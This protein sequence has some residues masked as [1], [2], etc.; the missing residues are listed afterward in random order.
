[1]S[2]AQHALDRRQAGRRARALFALLTDVYGADRVVLKAGRLGALR[3][4][5]SRRL[6]EQVLALQKLIYEDPTLQ[7]PPAD[8]GQALSDL[9]EEVADLIARRSLEERLERRVAE[10]MQ[11]RQEDYLR[12]IKLQVLKDDAGPENPYTQRKLEWLRRLEAVRLSRSAMEA[13]R[14]SSLDQVVGQERAI[15]AVMAKLCCPY[16]QHILLYGPPGVGKTTVARLVLAEAQRLGCSP[17]PPQ[18]PFVEV[19]GATL[20]WDPREVT[21]PL[22]GSVH[23]PI[24]QG[25]RRDLADGGVPEPKTGLVTEAHGGVLFIDEI[26]EI[27]PLLQYKL[28][29]VLEDKRV[30]YDSSYYDPGDQG[31]PAYIRKLFEEGAPADFVLIGATTRDPEEINPALRSR[32]AEVFFD[33]LT[34]GDIQRIVAEAAGRLGSRLEPGVPEL[35]SEYTIEARKAIGLLA[36]A[37]GLALH[38][39]LA[40]G[41]IDRERRAASDAGGPGGAEPP[42]PPLVIGLAEVR[43][44][45]SHSRLPPNLPRVA[46]QGCEVGR[47]FGVGV[48][49]F[50]GSVLE[51]EA[52]ALPAREKGKGQIRF[53]EAAGTM[54]RD[55]VFNAASVI[56]QL[57]GSDLSDYDLHI[58]LVGGG[59][60]DGPSAGAAVFLALYSAVTGSPL[61]QDLAVTGEVSIR[62]R[63]K[64]VGGIYEKIYGAKQAGMR[65]LVL[66]A[67]ASRELAGVRG[68]ELLYASEVR[69]LL[70]HALAGGAPAASLPWAP[71]PGA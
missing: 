61:R 51:V 63:V 38:S 24:Y 57:T 27:D 69:D 11:E 47:A 9:E 15:R 22:L 62:G 48:A 70:R 20:R 54:A 23:D 13:L 14:P 50:V 67:E 18:A 46:R 53:N 40:A 55:S 68:I 45:I 7:A 52:V 16:P 8:L 12:E 26:G 19:D 25:A 29:K 36:D 28:L 42:L 1:D 31:V 10:K 59:R 49:G 44:A 5:R 64:P 2:T 35:I 32:C 56:R 4:I 37:Y 21:N 34:P 3:G 66:P 39:S 30:T 60:V 17:F 65:A 6:E 58:N 71:G 41:G 43:E 33:P